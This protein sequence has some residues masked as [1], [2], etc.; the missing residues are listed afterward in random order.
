MVAA[1]VTVIPVERGGLDRIAQAVDQVMTRRY[2]DLPKEISDRQKP[3]VITDPRTSSLMV[4]AAPEDLDAIRGLVD[5]LAETPSNPAISLEVLTLDSAQATELAPRIESVMQDRRRSLGDAATDGD[6]VSIEIDEAS[7]SLIIA[8]NQENHEVVRDLV[9]VLTEAERN[10]IGGQAFEIVPVSRNRASD[11]LPLINEL[12]VDIENSRRGRNAVRVSSDA[13]LNAIL[14]SGTQAD[15][16]AIRGL[17]ERLDTERAGAIVELRYVPLTSANVLETVSLIESVLNGGGG[18]GRGRRGGGQVGTVMRYLQKIDGQE[19]DGMEVEVSSAI[20]D[21]I[22]LTPDVRTNTVIVSAPQES[23]ELIIQMINDLDNSSTGAKKIEVFKLVNADATATAELLT[24]LFQ[25]RQQ[26]N[27]YV[28]KPR[29]E[30]IEAPVLD[31][32]GVTIDAPIAETGGMFGTDL[33]LVP[34]ERQALS[35]TVDSRTNSLIVSGTPTYL[36][37]V[38][39]VVKDLD[40]QETNIRDT[41]VYKLRNA[42]ASEVARV[43]SEFVAED[44][45]KFVETLDNDQLPS[46]ARLLEREVTIVGDE[47]SNTVLVNASPQYMQEVQTIIEELDVDPPQVLIEVMLAEITLD[48]NSEWGLTNNGDVGILPINNSIEFSSNDIFSD[49][50]TG[51]FSVGIKDLRLVLTSMQAQGRLQ[52]LSNPSITVANNEDARIQVGKTIRVPDSLSVLDTGT[53]TSTITAEQI[54]TILEVRPSINPDGFVRLQI[55]P[56][57]SRLDGE[58]KVSEFVKSPVITRREATTTVTVK[59]GET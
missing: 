52:I 6:R 2:A 20:R 47:K 8:A 4:A 25:L 40:Q 26:G 23:M 41:Y 46:A 12:Y 53:Q 1:E 43:V 16:D 50:I 18:R 15:L 57:I 10:R 17:V 7:N 59:N 32:G 54:G 45:R 48:D 28:L 39:K 9:Q 30:I 34:D 42:Q 3:L 19:S 49:S 36:E 29:E 21:S 5:Q 11:L 27:L 24:E 14:V 44:Q 38:S 33:T 55:K 56:S 22:A 51:S 37:L 58:I 13:R 31:T 35:I